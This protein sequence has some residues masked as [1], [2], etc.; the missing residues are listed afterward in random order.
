MIIFT[1]S[2]IKLI[3]IKFDSNFIFSFT[4]NQ[5]T[6]A[7]NRSYHQHNQLR[8]LLSY[9]LLFGLNLMGRLVIAASHGS[10]SVIERKL[11]SR[12]VNTKYGSLRGVIATLPET[13]VQEVEVFLGM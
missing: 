4:V 6:M 10:D 7:S 8:Y 1:I 12:L 9:L 11:S 5:I 3:I 13:S 2:L